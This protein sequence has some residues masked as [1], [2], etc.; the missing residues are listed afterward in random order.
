MKKTLN[1]SAIAFA[2][3]AINAASCAYG[4]TVWQGDLFATKATAGCAV[5]GVVTG[6]M[7]QATYA[8]MGQNGN[9]KTQDQFVANLGK[10]NALQVVPASGGTLHGAPKVNTVS[11]GPQGGWGQGTNVTD[12]QITVSPFPV[13]AGAPV[14]ITFSISNSNTAC[15]ASFSGVLTPQPGIALN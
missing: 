4:Q 6:D 9:S 3:A 5:W 7:A 15:S 2:T 11:I 8:P 12:P 1:A 10:F 14:T 13:K